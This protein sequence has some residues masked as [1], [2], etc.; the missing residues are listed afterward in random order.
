MLNVQAR[1]RQT[2]AQRI[3]QSWVHHPPPESINFIP[4][5]PLE[6]AD[7]NLGHPSLSIDRTNQRV[8]LTLIRLRTRAWPIGLAE[9]LLQCLQ[10]ARK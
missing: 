5:D 9:K 7:V 6:N 4:L 1:L 2:H 3:G 8:Y 10:S